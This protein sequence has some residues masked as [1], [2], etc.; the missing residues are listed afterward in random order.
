MSTAQQVVI[1]HKTGNVY[2]YD[3]DTVH[4]LVDYDVP[5]AHHAVERPRCAVASAAADDYDVPAPGVTVTPAL[6][7]QPDDDVDFGVGDYDLLSPPQRPASDVV[8]SNRS[9]ITS[10]MSTGSASSGCAS[11]RSAGQSPSASG[12]GHG[13]CATGAR[14]VGGFDSQFGDQLAAR[15]C[16]GS[17][18][19]ADSGVSLPPA[20]N[21]PSRSAPSSMK[22]NGVYRNCSDDNDCF[23]Y[24]VPMQATFGE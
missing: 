2:V 12:V 4:Q 23:D 18:S 22:L 24:D 6:Y 11:V 20:F 15:R 5:T 14:L 10:V 9:S 8:S 13:A 17:A 16:A 7:R 19:S 3:D 1:P 21:S